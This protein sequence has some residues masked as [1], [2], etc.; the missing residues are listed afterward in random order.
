VASGHLIAEGLIR[1]TGVQGKR[2]Q[3]LPL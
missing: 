1:G 3:A 2:L